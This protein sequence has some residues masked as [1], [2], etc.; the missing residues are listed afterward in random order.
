MGKVVAFIGLLWAWFLGLRIGIA[1]LWLLFLYVLFGS[2]VVLSFSAFQW[3]LSVS[4]YTDTIGKQV[5]PGALMDI[6]DSWKRKSEELS[7]LRIQYDD[8]AALLAEKAKQVHILQRNMNRAYNDCRNA[9]TNFVM[10]KYES[11]QKVSGVH[12]NLLKNRIERNRFCRDNYPK[13]FIDGYLAA[14]LDSEPKKRENIQSTSLSR[15]MNFQDEYGKT[16]AI[17]SNIEY[18]E[19]NSY[20]RDQINQ[21]S[22]ALKTIAVN[23]SDRQS[24]QDY[25]NY[26]SLKIDRL[27]REQ[28]DLHHNGHAVDDQIKRY[29]VS[30]S[31]FEGI[32]T[33]PI[34]G[35]LIPD[36]SKMPPDTLTLI[37]VLAMGALGGTI[38][39]SRRHLR[40]VDNTNNETIQP[41]YYLFRP[42]L[43]AI[44]ALSVFILVKAGVLV[45][46]IPSPEGETANLS[47]FFISFLGIISGLLAEQALETIERVGQRFFTSSETAE[48]ARWAYGLAEAMKGVDATN[49]T[50]DKNL[51]E[52]S[53]ILEKSEDQISKWAKE[54]DKVPANFQKLIAAFFH[55]PLRTLFSDL[56]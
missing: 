1:G 32:E 19:I 8:A 10:E 15:S 56:K 27:S 44:T 26:T 34:I 30:F 5:G 12:A 24:T 42:F 49:A 43:G 31:Y 11:V 25:L 45:A 46:S 40:A 6:Y 14:L 16:K 2:F 50:Y 4:S 38:H 54:E 41:S 55:L 23:L 51:K 29:L 3:Q 48:P 36:F 21:A 13:E 39:L 18:V 7:S 17:L 20:V 28:A 53:T 9:I 52:L 22:D 47:P 33:R 35:Y 37:L